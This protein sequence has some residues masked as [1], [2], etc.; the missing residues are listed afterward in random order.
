MDVKQQACAHSS[1]SLACYFPPFI[2]ALCFIVNRHF[3]KVLIGIPLLGILLDFIIGEGL[4]DCFITSITLCFIF[5][6][7]Y[8]GYKL[9][10]KCQYIY[11]KQSMKPKLAVLFLIGLALLLGFVSYFF[12]LSEPY[13]IVDTGRYKYHGWTFGLFLLSHS[14]FILYLLT[15]GIYRVVKGQVR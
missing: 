1:L 8:M 13:A 15:F 4:I 9:V 6:Y 14:I 7:I 2:K 3:K 10:E 5:V 11:L 12:Y